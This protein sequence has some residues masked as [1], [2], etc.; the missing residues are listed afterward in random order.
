MVDPSAFTLIHFHGNGEAVADDVD[1]CSDL[2]TKQWGTLAV[3]VELSDD[4]VP[5]VES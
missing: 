3:E 5:S 1:V 2:A 4:D